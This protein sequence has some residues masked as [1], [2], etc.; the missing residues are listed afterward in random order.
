MGFTPE[1]RT[2]GYA[3]RIVFLEPSFS[4]VRIGEYLEVVG[5]AN[6]LAGIDVDQH[7]HW[8]LFSFR[9]PQWVSLRSGL[10]TRSTRRFNAFMTAIRAIIVGPLRA[11]SISASIAA[12]H[13]GKSDSFF[14]SL[15][16]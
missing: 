6:L 9:L 10:N 8:S 2:Q 13:S 3:F 11:T 4:G 16:M 12:C 5:V 14:G 15:V 1:P 7:R